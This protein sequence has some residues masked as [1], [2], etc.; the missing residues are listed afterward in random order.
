MGVRLGLW[1][2]ASAKMRALWERRAR[3][4]VAGWVRNAHRDHMVRYYAHILARKNTAG[5]GFPNTTFRANVLEKALLRTLVETLLV[6]PEL[7]DVLRRVVEA[8]HNARKP[9]SPV[10]LAEHAGQS[11]Y[12]LRE[13]AA[14]R[15]VRLFDPD[16]PPHLRKDKQLHRGEGGRRLCVVYGPLVGGV[17]WGG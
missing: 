16:V 8:V 4:E 5:A 12:P 3:G 17:Y 10:A 9:A 7:R 2:V 13:R 1:E 6:I 14:E 15:I 11:P